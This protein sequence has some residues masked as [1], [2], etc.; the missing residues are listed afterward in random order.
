MVE[1]SV[2]VYLSC[3]LRCKRFGYLLD[4]T[5]CAGKSMCGDMY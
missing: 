3:E 4:R 5:S 2:M 1:E